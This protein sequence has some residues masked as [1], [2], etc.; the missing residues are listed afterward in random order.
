LAKDEATPPRP[1]VVAAIQAALAEPGMLRKVV[2]FAR[3]RVF[4]LRRFGVGIHLDADDLAHQVVVDTWSGVL[5]WDPDKVA[6][7]THL[8][9]AISGRTAKLIERHKPAAPESVI[10][11]AVAAALVEPR[12]PAAP[13][14]RVDPAAV[15]GSM[16]ERDPV[17]TTV[18]RRD[19]LRKVKDY[20]IRVA[21]EN[22]DEEVQYVLIAYEQG[23]EGRSAIA[24]ATGLTPAQVTNARKRLDRYIRDMPAELAEDA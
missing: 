2:G 5:T 21:G 14:D 23:V 9:G 10:D 3:K 22:G 17:G 6:L 18:W 19:V 16:V 15:R 1:E 4:L 8:C 7:L 11:R 20:L 24:E 12:D 13:K